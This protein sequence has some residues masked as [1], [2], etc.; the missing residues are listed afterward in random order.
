MK[1]V[2]VIAPHPDD[3]T[4]GCGG[5]ILK[6][7]SEG[8][9]VYWLILTSMQKKYGW[10]KNKIKK[11]ELEIKKV[12]KM[13][14]FSKKFELNFPTCRLENFPISEIIEKISK[15]IKEIN[16]E[17][18]Y[19]PYSFDC[20]TDHQITA[21]ALQ[22]CI[23]WFR[24]P[25]IKKVLMYE[26]ISETNFNFI[27]KNNFQPNVFIDISKFIDKKINIMK[28]YKSE[29]TS[30]PFPRNEK[31]IRS[32]A[33]IRGSQSGYFSAESFNLVLER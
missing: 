13:Y 10:N 32:L 33:I 18:I 23:K 24:F 20:H 15:V 27:D 25:S 26:T 30:H 28:I 4:L 22:A 2:L 21:K 1:K 7:K 8:S 19:F 6:N 11:R 17:I 3:E 14:G 9:K 31:A 29:I 12:N 16:P 5:T